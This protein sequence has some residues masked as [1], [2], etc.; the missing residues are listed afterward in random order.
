MG[1]AE[2]CESIGIVWSSAS[3]RFDGGTT[4]LEPATET[5]S[6]REAIFRTPTI[7]ILLGAFLAPSATHE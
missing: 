6:S 7:R 2:R 1:L 3:C 5:T 4:P